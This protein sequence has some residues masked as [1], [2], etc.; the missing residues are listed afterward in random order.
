MVSSC[1]IFGQDSDT[2]ELLEKLVVTKVVDGE[3][4]PTALN[5][6]KC[7]FFFNPP[8][9]PDCRQVIAFTE[10]KMV[11]D[12]IYLS[13]CFY[14]DTAVGEELKLERMDFGMPLSSNSADYANSFTGKM[15]LKAVNRH[16]AVILMENVHFTIAHGE[17][18]LN[19][20]LVATK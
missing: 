6:T 8:D 5:F 19:G 15:I 2:S 11:D 13:F 10:G 14:D 18:V 20:D 16:K 17:F 4:S 3:T 7:S 12:V 9:V 1:G